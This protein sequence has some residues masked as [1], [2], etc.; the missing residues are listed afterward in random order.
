MTVYDYIWRVAKYFIFY[1]DIYNPG[2]D[3][4]NDGAAIAYILFFHNKWMVGNYFFKSLFT[5]DQC[6]F[7]F[8]KFLVSF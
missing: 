2:P 1:R 7:L 8:I 3:T 6:L 5:H 4:F